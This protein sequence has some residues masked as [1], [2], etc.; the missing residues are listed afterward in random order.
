M[1]ANELNPNWNWGPAWNGIKRDLTTLAWL[2]EEERAIQRLYI[3]SAF[4]AMTGRREKVANFA[5]QMGLGAA[6]A[7]TIDEY[8]RAASGALDTGSKGEVGNRNDC[9]RCNC[10]GETKED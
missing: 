10:E 5:R 2:F 4:W 1:S 3:E 6:S 9:Q 8:Q 7:S